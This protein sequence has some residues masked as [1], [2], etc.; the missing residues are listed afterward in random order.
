MISLKTRN[1]LITLLHNELEVPVI[2]ADQ[3]QPEAEYPFVI[4]KFLNP[5]MS[6][7]VSGNIFTE[8][9]D[10]KHI[11]NIREEQAEAT[12]SFTVCSMNR[13][14]DDKWISGE[15]EIIELTDKAIS[16]FLHRGYQQLTEIGIV[17]IE[18]M[19]TGDRSFLQVD[20]VARQYGFDVR[21]RYTYR[22]VRKDSAVQSYKI[23]K[24]E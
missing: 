1:K 10:D 15:D 13:K 12:I 8:V 17:I 6:R 11:D 23:K 4:Y 24:E 14:V 16:W 7:G 18:V 9:V 3:V 2:L 21:I 20:E 22:T 5:Y 19:N